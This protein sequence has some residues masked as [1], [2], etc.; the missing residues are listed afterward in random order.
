MSELSTLLP[1]AVG[2]AISPLP[3][4]AVVAILLSTR[5]RAAAPAYTGAFLAVTLA[6]IA[7]GAAT[8]A[9]ASAASHG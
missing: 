2:M 1:L 7:V 9:G 6:V 8:S 4:V 5:G 3:I